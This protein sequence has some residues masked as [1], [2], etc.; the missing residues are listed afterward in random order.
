M[1]NDN[2]FKKGSKLLIAVLGGLRWRGKG[3]VLDCQTLKLGFLHMRCVWRKFNCDKLRPPRRHCMS[4]CPW[5]IKNRPPT[6]LM[7]VETRARVKWICQVFQHKHG[8]VVSMFTSRRTVT[9]SIVINYTKFY[10][11]ETCLMPTCRKGKTGK[12]WGNGE[13]FV[14]PTF[15]LFNPHHVLP[16]SKLNKRG[17]GWSIARCCEHLKWLVSKKIFFLAEGR[18][19]EMVQTGVEG[20]GSKALQTVERTTGRRRVEVSYYNSDL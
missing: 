18:A 7:W 5:N 15:R 13:K 14:N 1:G 3:T 11:D 2:Y 6:R 10:V 9:M 16:S 19:W 17:G 12:H 8:D 4:G 20:L